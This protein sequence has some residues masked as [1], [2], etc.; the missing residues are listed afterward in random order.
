MH[1][2]DFICSAREILS[3]PRL[4]PPPTAG[5]TEAALCMIELSYWQAATHAPATTH[6]LISIRFQHVV[7]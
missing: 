2:N 3:L 6:C 7:R 5:P 4:A 1:A